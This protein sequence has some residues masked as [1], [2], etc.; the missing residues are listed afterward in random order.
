VRLATVMLGLSLFACSEVENPPPRNPAPER[1]VEV[2]DEADEE[3]GSTLDSLGYVEFA[4]EQDEGEGE[5]VVLHRVGEA[6]PGYY[7]VCAIPFAT[8]VLIDG[9]GN[10]LRRWSDE[11]GGTWVRAR[12]LGN[13]DLIV[14]GRGTGEKGY[15]IQRRSW[16]DEVLWTKGMKAHHD[17]RELH[18]GRLLALTWGFNQLA[19]LEL[20]QLPEFEKKPKIKD[21]LLIE[22]SP[23]GELLLET[24]LGR[25]LARNNDE[26]GVT[27]PEEWDPATEP[28]PD[29]FHCNSIFLMEDGELAKRDPIYAVGNVLVSSRY[30]NLLFIVD[31]R[32]GDLLWH[33]RPPG[34][35][36]QHEA[37][38]L[39]SGNILFFDNGREER[40]YSRLVELNPLTKEI[41]WE[42]TAPEPSDFFSQARGTV[43]EVEDG[44]LLVANSDRGEAFQ[45]NREGEV[46]WRYLTP[47]T[48]E[49]GVRGVIR[50]QYYPRAF[51]DGL[52]K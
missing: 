21:D 42:Y 35:E 14:V 39:A 16:S 46:L 7:L 28:E 3:R 22:L 23:E 31:R 18:D 12:L 10:E 33:W 32:T 6:A 2:Q 44:V 37:S 9:D 27:V 49:E 43:A 20:G 48:N 24:S 15:V 40:G 4:S 45:I 34:A 50:I 52:S 36:W 8:A 41:V 11:A 38:V 17:I 1:V 30:Q 26:V 13:G 5:G 29:M 51:I 19:R 47:F 25:S